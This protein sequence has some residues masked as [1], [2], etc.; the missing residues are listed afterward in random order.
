MGPGMVTRKR[1][2]GVR[3]LLKA[4]AF[5]GGLLLNMWLFYM[6]LIFWFLGYGQAALAL[7]CLLLALLVFMF[8]RATE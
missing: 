5:V 6:C 3:V 1:G 8:A 2:C 4:L 7:V